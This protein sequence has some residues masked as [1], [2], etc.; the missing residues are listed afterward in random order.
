MPLNIIIF[1]G[2]FKNSQ[3]FPFDLTVTAK[4]NSDFHNLIEIILK[5]QSVSISFGSICN[6]ELPP[7]KLGGIKGSE[8][9][10]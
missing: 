2:D 5:R 4:S 9:E 6:S 10:A 7:S 1:K 3:K 8:L